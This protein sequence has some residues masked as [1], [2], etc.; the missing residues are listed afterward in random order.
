[1]EACVHCPRSD[2]RRFVVGVGAV[3]RTWYTKAK[4]PS[5]RSFF[6]A[7]PRGNA[8]NVTVRPTKSLMCTRL[9]ST[10][11]DVV[12]SRNMHATVRRGPHDYNFWITIGDRYFSGNLPTCCHKKN[13][14]F[15]L[16]YARR[17]WWRIQTS[18]YDSSTGRKTSS[19]G[20]SWATACFLGSGPLEI[21]PR[22]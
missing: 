21:D 22:P 13:E 15:S 1:M 9:A 7:N 19:R 20:A 17:F 4:P 18:A 2:P 14:G 6:T 3:P 12:F 10:S 5:P 16:C 11:L 8:L